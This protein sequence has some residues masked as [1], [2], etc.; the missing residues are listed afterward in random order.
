MID[1]KELTERRMEVMR[2]QRRWRDSNEEIET[3]RAHAEQRVIDA[4]YGG[5]A[6]LLGSNA[7]ERERRLLIALERDDWWRTQ[8]RA[9]Q[10]A[11]SAYDLAKV[12]LDEILDARR[13]YE[14]EIRDR[15]V[16][17]LTYATLER[18]A[19]PVDADAL[20]LAHEVEEAEHR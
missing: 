8:Q 3:E 15:L 2:A 13:A 17:A 1:L 6:K 9:H 12:R 19:Q 18:E 16:M 7:D 20:G 4:D 14:W 10:D 5:D 11:I